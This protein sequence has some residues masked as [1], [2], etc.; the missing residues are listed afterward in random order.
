MELTPE[1]YL[2]RTSKVGQ[3]SLTNMFAANATKPNATI[4]AAR[5][6]LKAN[7]RTEI[8]IFA[9]NPWERLVSNFHY[10]NG[11]TNQG[12]WPNSYG[13]AKVS[14]ETF[15]DNMA[16]RANNHHWAP[17]I[18]LHGGTDNFLPT[19][20]WRFDDF[21]RVCREYLGFN[22]EIEVRN[23]SK[24]ENRLPVDPDYRNAELLEFFADDWNLYLN[25]RFP[26]QDQET[27]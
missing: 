27:T 19:H 13:T 1:L 10:F 7:P 20:V 8:H 5:A 12:G 17:Q 3:T 22:R 23:A 21:E 11:R 2:G 16:L 6:A 18:D 15:V 25:A 14:W 9:R 26:G 24:R 4:K